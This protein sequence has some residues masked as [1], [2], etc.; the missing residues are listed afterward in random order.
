MEAIILAGGKAERLGAASGGRPKALVPVAER[1]LA[2][3]QI[4]L[5]AA[6]GVE[7]VLVSCAA[8]Q[9]QLFLAELGGLGPE[10]VPVPG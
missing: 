9:E 3:Y 10:V 4:D 8:G 7:R 5:L 2:A 1:P 6:A